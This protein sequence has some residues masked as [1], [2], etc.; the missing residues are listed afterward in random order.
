MYAKLLNG[1]LMVAPLNMICEIEVKG[2]EKKYQVFNP[3]PEQY[4][5]AG[6]LPVIETD[7]P[8]NDESNFK[9]YEKVYTERDG[10][11]YGEWAEC[12]APQNDTPAPSYEERIA[13]LEEE[14]A[15]AKILLGVE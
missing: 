5:N 8:E 7:Y 1:I 15:A 13:A 4:T 6:Y 2:I 14:L 3:T 12:D 9:Y 11:I 10:I